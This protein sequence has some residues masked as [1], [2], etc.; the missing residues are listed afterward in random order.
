MN[1]LKIE[2]QAKTN[3]DAQNA[4]RSIIRELNLG[5]KKG[6]GWVFGEG[7]LEHTSQPRAKLLNPQLVDLSS[8]LQMLVEGK[9]IREAGAE[10]VESLAR[11]LPLLADALSAEGYGIPKGP[12]ASESSSG[13]GSEGK[14]EESVE[15]GEKAPENAS[16]EATGDAPKVEKKR[17]PWDPRS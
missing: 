15:S 17:F 2:R 9:D 7:E 8:Q 4:L 12:E 6:D 1:I 10:D 11:I 13:D 16:Q 3:G 5:R 14:V